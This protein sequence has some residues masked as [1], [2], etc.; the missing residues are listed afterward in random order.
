MTDTLPTAKEDSELVPIGNSIYLDPV[1]FEHAKTVAK[2]LRASDLVPESYRRNPA[3]IMIALDQAARLNLSP[4]FLMQRMSVVKGKPVIEG[5]LVIALVNERGPFK[6]PLE[7]ILEGQGDARKCTCKGVR[8]DNG[9]V[10]ETAVSVAM[11]KK[12]G[13]Y[14][15]NP[16]WEAMTDQMLM[17]RSAMF[18][19]RVHCPEVIFGMSM[20]DEII[21]VTGNEEKVIQQGNKISALNER[22][23]KN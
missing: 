7:F 8:R 5:Q 19:S 20:K 4:V 18:L 22:L 1:A 17:Y 13:W 15:R 14:S 6:D 11:A 23:S 2:M 16:L 3:D 21:D 10:C 9:R 12:V